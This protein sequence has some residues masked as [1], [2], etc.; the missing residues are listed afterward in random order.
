MNKKMIMTDKRA[1]VCGSSKGIGA[2][3]AIELSKL[4]ASIVLL[5]RNEDSLSD[6]LNRLDSSSNQKHSYLI[7]DFDDPDELKNK[8][9]NFVNEN[10]PIH[11]L[12][13]NS[14][15]PKPGPIVDADIEDFMNAFKRHLICNHI[16][17]QVLIPNMKKEKFGRIINITSTS[18][19]QPIKGLG[20]SNTIRGA[21]ANWAKTLSFELGEY[22]I[23]VNNILPGYTDTQRLQEIFLNKSKKSNF[24]IESII[25]DA[26]S[27]IPLGRFAD[28][29]ETA[30]AICFLASEDA[31]YINGINLPVDGGRLSTL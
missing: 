27:Q 30:K 5:A 16:L 6:I 22:G 20:I 8:I 9:T 11:I 2:E 1:L 10:P 31:A 17:V 3:T 19:K 13:N 28:P 26:H 7:A 12:I 25:S 29:K 23:T 15:G 21:V 18:V 4:G 14:G 24:D